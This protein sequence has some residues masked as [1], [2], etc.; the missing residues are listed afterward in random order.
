MHTTLQ[1]KTLQQTVASAFVYVKEKWGSYWK[2]NLQAG[3]KC[4]WR[5]W[6]DGHQV[7][8]GI[9]CR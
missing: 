7:N 4:V 5:A 9:C 8:S 2:F 6:L 1:K 3:G